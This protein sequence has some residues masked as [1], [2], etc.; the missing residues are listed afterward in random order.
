MRKPLPLNSLKLS[1]VNTLSAYFTQIIGRDISS[2]PTVKRIEYN[3]DNK[4]Y[5][6]FIVAGS[7]LRARNFSVSE[8]EIS[9]SKIKMIVGQFFPALITTATTITGALSFEILK[10]NFV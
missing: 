8:T 7:L 3:R 9:E 2:Y 5:A 6:D 4:L 1:K 10:L